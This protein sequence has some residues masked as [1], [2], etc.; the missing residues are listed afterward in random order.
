[1]AWRGGNGGF[2]SGE[3]EMTM[4]AENRKQQWRHLWRKRMAAMTGWR[5]GGAPQTLGRRRRGREEGRG[6]YEKMRREIYRLFSQP[7]SAGV[8][9][10]LACESQSALITAWRPAIVA[11]EST[12]VASAGGYTSCGYIWL[13]VREIYSA[14]AARNGNGGSAS[15]RWRRMAACGGGVGGR[16]NREENHQWREMAASVMVSK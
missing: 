10:Q 3:T 15:L 7:L 1:V 4:K 6:K 2:F 11:A 16:R 8:A 12:C 14:K 5:N 9:C 13:N